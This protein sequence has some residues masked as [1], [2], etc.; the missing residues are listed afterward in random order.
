MARSSSR[1]RHFCQKTDV[2]FSE[3]GV[4]ALRRIETLLG[5]DGGKG[6]AERYSALL[7]GPALRAS[8]SWR[9]SV[10]YRRRACMQ[11]A[12]CL[13]RSGTS[14]RRAGLNGNWATTYMAVQFSRL[15]MSF[16]KSL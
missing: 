9:L 4:L 10:C 11:W 7:E 15:Q 6:V 13:F 2:L 1:P 14:I 5:T 3:L 16:C 8:Q 12:L